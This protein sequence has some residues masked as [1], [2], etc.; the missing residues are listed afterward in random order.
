[1]VSMLRYDPSA[2]LSHCPL[3]HCSLF[4]CSTGVQWEVVP[5]QTDWAKCKEIENLVGPYD[6]WCELVG[7]QPANQVIAT[8]Y[9]NGD[10]GIGAHFDKAKSIAPSSEVSG[11]SLITVVKMG[12]CGR[13]FNLYMLGEEAPFWSEVVPA[14]WAI[15]MT[16]EANLQTKHEVP[17]VKDG[18]IGNSGSLVW[19]TISDVRTAQ[20]V[21][22]LVEA[23]RRQKKRM[24]DAKGTR[25]RQR[26]KRGSSTR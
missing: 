4:A 1:M 25:L 7:A 19:R 26:E 13:P 12:D 3:S 2:P 11:V 22:K 20:Q 10:Y 21:N 6:K 14:G 24:R 17:M 5:A 23:S 8:A 9:R 16:L 18:G 15:V